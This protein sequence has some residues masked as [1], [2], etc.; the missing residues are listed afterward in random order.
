[1]GKGL[2]IDS[3]LEK[4]FDKGDFVLVPI[5][6]E[7]GKPSRWQFIL[8]SE[9]LRT[10]KI[11]VPSRYRKIGDFDGAELEFKNDNRPA[12]RFLY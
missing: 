4:Q 3:A 1:M 5:P 9:K 8:M 6:T 7:H 2:I 11:V 10:R 12:H